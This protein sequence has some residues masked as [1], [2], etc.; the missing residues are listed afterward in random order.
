M[1]P[2]KPPRAKTRDER[3]TPA[4]GLMVSRVEADEEPTPPPQQMPVIPRTESALRLDAIETQVRTLTDGVGEVWDARGISRRMDRVEVEL[5]DNTKST[6]RTEAVLTEMVVPAVKDMMAKVDTCMHH[7]AAS[8]HL[9]A[10]VA[11]LAEKVDSG[12]EKLNKIEAEQKT[13]AERFEIH[14]QRD[15]EF[16]TRIENNATRLTAVEGRL[17]IVDNTAALER[18]AKEDKLAERVSKA[19]SV[20]PWYRTAKGMTAV[21]TALATGIGVVIAAIYAG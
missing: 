11:Q 19:A 16:H 17:A 5:R 20:V 14:D 9:A 3:S 10:N 15:R 18:K 21:I 6:V 4:S 1:S 7:I 2:L 13:A 12:I 8:S